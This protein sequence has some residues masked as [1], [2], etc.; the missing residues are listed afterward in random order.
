MRALV[1]VEGEE[2]LEGA[3]HGCGGGEVTAAEGDS[4]VFVED[5]SLEPFDE[6]VGP[7]VT[8]LGSGVVDAELGADGVEESL[9]LAAVVGEDAFELPAGLPVGGQENALKEAR[10]MDR[11]DEGM[12]WAKAKEQAA[13]QAVT[14][15]SLAHAL[16]WPM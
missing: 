10:A 6:A 2:A 5:G 9:E 11:L 14:C 3:I 7:A 4:P 16:S 13:S 12:T 1:V 8:G 15:Q